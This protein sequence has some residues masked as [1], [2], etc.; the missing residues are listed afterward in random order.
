MRALVVILGLVTLVVTTACQSPYATLSDKTIELPAPDRR[1]IL[2]YHVLRTNPISADT[3][4]KASVTGLVNNPGVVELPKG[5][6]LLEAIIGAGGFAE[7]AYFKQI[8]V[9]HGGTKYS[10]VLCQVNEVRTGRSWA[11]YA[12]GGKN[13]KGRFVTVSST[14]SDYILEDETHVNV[15]LRHRPY[16]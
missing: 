2:K 15:R 16:R 13:Y 7:W 6:T 8:F 11:W 10:L 12:P 1:E 4:I 14:K 9:S 5:S 3:K